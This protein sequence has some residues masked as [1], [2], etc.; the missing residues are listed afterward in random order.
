MSRQNPIGFAFSMLVE[1]A[2]VAAI[3]SFLPRVNLRP[4]AAATSSSPTA[5]TGPSAAAEPVISPV[6]WNSPISANANPPAHE[7]SYY[8][9]AIEPTATNSSHAQAPEREAPPL[10]TADLPNPAY[11]EQ[12]LDRASQQLVN[13]VGTYMTQAA[14]S[15][16]ANPPQAA[17]GLPA[18]APQ[19]AYSPPSFPTQAAAPSFKAPQV[20]VPPPAV[21][22][23]RPAA[24]SARTPPRPWI[25]Y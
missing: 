8:R 10:L 1:I 2:A 6:S 12:R 17:T 13:S 14:G 9:R 4:A 23:R 24:A 19:S 16:L 15:L 21:P 22:S 7:T 25:R 3:V 18:S 20:A 5:G 11:V